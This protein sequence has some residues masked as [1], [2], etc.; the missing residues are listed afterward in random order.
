MFEF[1]PD[2]V[3]D[4]DEEADDTKG[5][6][7]GDEVN[8]LLDGMTDSTKYQ[9]YNIIKCNVTLKIEMFYMFICS[10]TL[11]TPCLFPVLS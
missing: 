2:L 4:D 5:D 3:D 8:L 6:D 10:T 11:R 1:L 9:S 7:D